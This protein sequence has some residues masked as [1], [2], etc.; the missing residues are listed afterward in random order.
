MKYPD[1][2][3]IVQRSLK[4]F[5]HDDK[6][7][8]YMGGSYETSKLIGKYKIDFD[9][10]P[11]GDIQFII[12]NPTTPC[13]VVYVHKDSRIAELNSLDYSP[14]CTVDGNMIRGEGTRD[15]IEFAL[16]VAKK[17]GAKVI[18]L[19]D[20]STI[21]CE[22]GEK[23]KLGPFYFIRHGVTW[24]EKYFG[25]KPTLEFKDEYK[26]AKKLRTRLNL[27]D[28]KTRPCNYFTR[29]TTD[30]ILRSLELSFHSIVWEKTL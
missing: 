2:D 4:R 23:I 15:M 30:T 13:L 10:Q 7:V 17:M 3:R 8:R 5:D 19:Q 6:W 16:A 22:S 27:E 12:W 25:F 11:N 14:R 18:Q 24:Y 9:R 28:L 1:I 20:E 21:K 29:K 26:E